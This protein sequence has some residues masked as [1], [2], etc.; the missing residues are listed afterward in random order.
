MDFPFKINTQFYILWDILI[1]NICTMLL[2]GYPAQTPLGGGSRTCGIKDIDPEDQVRNWSRLIYYGCGGDLYTFLS[3][4]KRNH[5]QKG[6]IVHFSLV[7]IT[8]PDI[9]SHRAQ[10]QILGW[11]KG[12][13]AVRRFFLPSMR[14]FPPGLCNK[15]KLVDWFILQNV[16]DETNLL[17]LLLKHLSV[18]CVGKLQLFVLFIMNCEWLQPTAQ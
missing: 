10:Q 15:L 7:H 6:C 17:F 18:P 12:K 1:Q 16:S 8:W 4:P 2:G 14:E 5:H 3:V 13:L 9:A 11:L